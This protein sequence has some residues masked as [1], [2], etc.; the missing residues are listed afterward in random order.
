[1][2]YDEIIVFILL[3][4]GL[5]LLFLPKR[6]FKL[7]KWSSIS[8]NITEKKREG[9]AGKKLGFYDKFKIK[10]EE[11]LKLSNSK[12]TYNQYLLMICLFSFLGVVVG[13]LLNNPLLSIILAIA[14]IF[15][16]MQVLKIKQTTYTQYL[17]EQIEHTLSMITNSYL[18][19]DDIVKSVKDNLPRIEQPMY[20]IFREFVTGNTFIDSNIVK[21]IRKM[22]SK[23]DNDGFNEWCNTLILSQNDRELKF[24]LPAIVEQMSDIKQMQEELNTMMYQIYR[25]YIL[26]A[27]VVLASIPFMRVLN[28]DWYSVLV[29]TLGGKCVVAIV[30]MTVILCLT[31]VIK[32]NKPVSS[33]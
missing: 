8:K 23:I 25:E 11:V 4:I 12:L 33:L 22:Q 3:F 29:G 15:L 10:S 19:C 31:Y 27:G 9:I 21:N 20:N 5:F 13:G 7:K 28:A 1:M 17:N 18:Q 2:I 30:V 6:K 32:V 16:P 26:V 14:M 24:V